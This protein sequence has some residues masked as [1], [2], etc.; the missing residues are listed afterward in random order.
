MPVFVSPDAAHLA[1]A[2]ARLV[3]G[4]IREW[5]G[6]VVTIAMAGGSTPQAMYR[7][8]QDLDVPWDRVHAWIGD[9]RS[10]PPTHPDNNGAMV[11][12]EL[13]DGV[14]AAFSAVPWRADATPDELAAEYERTLLGILDADEDGPRPDLVLAGI[15]D[16]GHTLSL[17]PGTAAIDVTDRWYVAN[18]VPQKDT[19]R[20]TATY[21]LVHRSRLIVVLVAGAGKA[22]ALAE[23][24]E[25]T[26][27]ARLPAAR[28]MDGEA[29]VLWL[30]DAP[31]AAGLTGTTL[32]D[33]ADLG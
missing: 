28:L 1:D 11:R 30:V 32:H 14:G 25:P 27:E 13:L 24:L 31:A 8:L 18:H 15:G 10:V 9:E 21:P 3:A 5:S 4:R 6:D 22:A 29:E 33:A 19:W 2:A 16:D 12:R 7:R 26:H 20:L 17:F 23:I